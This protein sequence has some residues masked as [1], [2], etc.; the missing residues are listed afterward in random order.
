M[1]LWGWHLFGCQTDVCP[2]CNL[3]ASQILLLTKQEAANDSRAL[4]SVKP[5]TGG[6]AWKEELHRFHIAKERKYRTFL[7]NFKKP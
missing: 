5:L 3:T 1:I 4:L 2:H 7:E 6:T